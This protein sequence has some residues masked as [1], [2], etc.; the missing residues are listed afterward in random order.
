MFTDKAKEKFEEWFEDSYPSVY[1]GH[2]YPSMQWGVIQDFAESLGYCIT[3][4]LEHPTNLFKVMFSGID[5]IGLLTTSRQEARTE[6]IKKLN[7]L[8]NQ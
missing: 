8:I 3:I 2:L 6:A 4:E 7:E 5:F 1:L